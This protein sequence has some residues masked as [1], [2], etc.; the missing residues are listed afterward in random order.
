MV[1]AMAVSEFDVR[2]MNFSDILPAVKLD[3]SE[4]F[5]KSNIKRGLSTNAF[6]IVATEPE[7]RDVI[8][9]TTVWVPLSS[10]GS[11]SQGLQLVSVG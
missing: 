10:M 3:K 5:T 2:R 1:V 4:I 8:G 6:G 11:L 9:F 7:R